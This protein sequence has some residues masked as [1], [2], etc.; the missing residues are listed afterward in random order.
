M[1]RYVSIIGA[2][3]CCVMLKAQSAYT[4][5]YWFDHNHAQ[6]QQVPFANGHFLFDVS[7]LETGLHTLCVMLEGDD[8]TTT[9]SYMF[10]KMPTGNAPDLTCYYW[11]DQN[12]EQIQQVPFGNGILL[13]DVSGIDEGLHTVNITLKGNDFTTTT[14]YLFARVAINGDPAEYQ[15]HCWFDDDLSTEQTGLLG[16]GYFQLNVDGLVDGLH[17]VTVQVDNGERFSAPQSYW[18]Y[19]QPLGGYG[20]AKWAYWLNDNVSGKIVTDIVPSQDTLDIVT[21]LPVETCPIR[22]SCFHFHPNGDEPYI[23][24]KNKVT[25][26]FWDTGDRYVEQSALYVDENVSEPII[27]DILEFDTTVCIAAPNNNYIQWYKMTLAVGDSVAFK[28][29]KACTMQ[30]FAPSGEEVYAA[31]GGD[32]MVFG[33]IHAWEDGD[34]Y[35]A[36]HDATG[37][38]NEICL[39]NVYVHK[40]AVL[41]YDAHIVGNGGCSTITFQGNGFDSLLSVCF[42]NVQNDSIKH[43]DIGHESNTTTTVAF[44]FFDATLGIYDAVFQF[45][46]EEIRI[47]EALEVK[48]PEDIELT[49]AVSYPTTFL[50]DMPCTYT[51]T[52]TNNGN[53]SA[54]AVPVYL[55]ISSSTFDGISHLELEGMNLPPLSEYFGADSLSESE[56]EAIEAWV[57]E[58][59]EDFYFFKTMSIDENTG[60]SI[61]IRSSCFFINL[62]PYETKTFSL[63]ITSSETLNVWMTTPSDV[64]LPLTLA[65]GREVRDTYCCAKDWMTCRLDAIC[66]T[67]D[68]VGLVSEVTPNAS[69]DLIETAANSA[70]DFA[71]LV[72]T[73]LS[74]ILCDSGD[75]SSFFEFIHAI[76]SNSMI[77][78]MASCLKQNIPD[79]QMSDL[80]SKLMTLYVIGDLEAMNNCTSNVNSVNP[81]D[82]FASNMQGGLSSSTNSV[83]P[84]DIRGYLSESGSRYMRQEI[85]NVQYEIEFENDTTL[86]TAAAHTIVVRDTL[87]VSKFDLN[88]LAARSVTIGDKRLELNGEQTFARTLDMRPEINVVAQIEQKCYV[89]SGIVEWT[90]QSLDPM[91]MEPTDDPLQGVLPMNYSGNGV[92]F[93]N[94]SI[95]LKEAFADGTEISNRAGIVFDQNDVI[96]TPTWTNTIDAV[97]PV[98]HIETAILV[99]DSLRFNIVSSDNR[100]GV[101]YHTLYY[102]NDS[103][104]Q[105]WQVRKARLFGNILMLETEGLQTT[106]YLVMAVDSAGNREEK[107]MVAEYIFGVYY[108]I[109]ATANPAAGGTIEGADTYVHGSTATLIATPNQ[110]YVFDN[111]TENGVVVSVDSSYSFTVTA[112]R[113]LVANFIF[114]DGIIEQNGIEANI[115][116]N[117]TN[118]KITVEAENL[119]RVS[120]FNTFGQKVFEASASGNNTEC[121]L[122]GCAIGVYSMQIETTNGIVTKRVVVEK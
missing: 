19:K 76:N 96:M 106:E 2:L 15:Y 77:G 117:P 62:A 92:G 28:T 16:A 30:L 44:D 60:D 91:T 111:W 31:T 45:D 7:E 86:A 47:E 63:Q 85:Q 26:R 12:Y 103:T 20:I 24:A 110:N 23:N 107:D 35:L 9:T 99:G 49:P 6:M 4:C 68:W 33:G 36:V 116:P 61:C 84:N 17:T 69:M 66:S 64:V 78:A 89:N 56:I 25:F 121:D 38:S 79:V 90:I 1:K 3:L 57:G 93:I 18:F 108:E 54:Y 29:D 8:Y 42:V 72:N 65:Q 102:R 97:N 41:A 80:L 104:N 55:Y 67:T 109:T 120:V 32:V 98:S 53:M 82:C 118:G 51:Y 14:N 46:G 34:Y 83:D 95:D 105:E 100:S 73:R 43:L 13:L 114:V 94:Y 50:S 27:A 70:N 5:H 58:T 21:L 75:E 22:S 87:D 119:R 122:R 81:F 113:A 40:Y 48:S 112:N 88:T 59:A 52:I 115:Y 10:A 101:W 71:N 39:T 11:F 37:S 74:L